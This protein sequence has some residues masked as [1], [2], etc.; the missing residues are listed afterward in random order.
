METS[1]MKSG[2]TAE[3]RS[4]P[5]PNAGNKHCCLNRLPGLVDYGVFTVFIKI[6]YL[7][8]MSIVTSVL[9]FFK[10]DSMQTC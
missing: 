8:I 10:V 6:N 5:L 7:C 9:C 1:H 2:V 3:I 4:G